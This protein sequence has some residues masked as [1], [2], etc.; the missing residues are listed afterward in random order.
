MDQAILAIL[1]RQEIEELLCR[2]CR[3]LDRLDEPLL[4]GCFH[5]D[6]QHNHG[7]VGPS[8]EF[9]GYA[10]DVL[11]ACVATHHHLGNRSIR[12]DGHHADAECYFTAYHRVGATPIEAFGSDSA[13]KDVLVGGRYIDRLEK[14]GG[15][16]R[17][18]SRTGVHDWQRIEEAA[19]GGFF[20]RPADQR[21]RR[22]RT[23]A[24]YARKG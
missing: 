3:A 4:R 22:D 15:Q 11:R 16:W 24:V 5:P 19:D 23:D 9:C 7:Y 21:G 8:E 17:I 10:M 6:S 12:V 13:G 2:Y 1:D 18:V 14:R 20:D